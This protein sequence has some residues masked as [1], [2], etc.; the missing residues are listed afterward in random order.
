MNDSIQPLRLYQTTVSP[1]WIDYNGHMSEAYYVLVFGHATDAFYDLIGMDDAFRRTTRTSVYTVE[2]HVNYLLEATEGQVLD[3]ETL[4]LGRDPKRVV[5]FHTMRWGNAGPVLATTEVM[6]LNVDKVSL[7]AA[8]FH[9]KTAARIAAFAAD[10]A[11]L[12]RPENAGRRIAILSGPS[13]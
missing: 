3:I 4:V 10:H 6:A 13:G 9:P 7:K 11:R 1:D 12:A 8:P 5:L 2:A